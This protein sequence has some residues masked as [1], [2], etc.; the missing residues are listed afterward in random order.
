MLNICL[1]GVSGFA[2]VHYED[3]LR[4]VARGLMRLVGATV[5]NANEEPEKCRVLRELGCEIFADHRAM[6]EKFAG[7]LDLCI[8]PTGLH[9]HAAMTLDALRAG[10]N[11]L[12]E[13]PAAATIQDVRAM[14]EGE[15]A[16]N[17]FVAVGFQNIY[18]RETLWMKRAILNGEIGVL[19]CV[20]TRCL[21]S[22]GTS[23]YARNRWAGRLKIPCGE[24]QT[25][26]LDSPF[27]NAVAHQLN[28]IAFL[29]GTEL[30]RSAALHSIEAELNRA[31]D[32]ESPDT[33]ALRAV[34]REGV[35]LLFLATHCPQNQLDPEIEVRGDKGRIH[36][37][38]ER[39]VIERNDGSCEEMPSESGQSLRD[40]LLTS[41]ARRVHE[42][43]TFICD[44]D[45]AAAQTVLANGA[46]E[47]SPVHA[48]DAR[49]I[50]RETHGANVK[51]IIE[52]VDDFIARAYNE[53][54]LGSELGVPWARRGQTVSLEGYDHFPRSST[55]SLG[56]TR[57]ST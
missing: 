42:P 3:V 18:G 40:T 20:K 46:H 43:Q 29:A 38:Y 54:K 44:L 1:I 55:Q 39:A 5:I 12:V 16:A 51:T 21:W 10:A 45:I 48:I 26:V 27:N 11:V 14:Q 6:L 50:R 31:H 53:E 13:K 8:I 47:S 17:R 30:S 7:R 36:W 37:T 32:I 52:G 9:L 2:N 57:G 23:Y 19:E 28:M 33:A 41:V 56:E 24:G 25:W 35:K 15:R 49:F 4:Q 22:R 34:S